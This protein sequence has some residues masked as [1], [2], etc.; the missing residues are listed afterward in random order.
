MT[1]SGPIVPNL[2]GDWC[3]TP[4]ENITTT[5]GETIVP[6]TIEATNIEGS[7]SYFGDGRCPA[8]Y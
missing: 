2:V 1:Q 3:R 7:Y 4:L 5:E 8:A 6:T